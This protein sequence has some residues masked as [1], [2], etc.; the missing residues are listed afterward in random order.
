[1]RTVTYPSSDGCIFLDRDPKHF[2]Y[3]LNYLRTNKLHLPNP[4]TEPGL[5]A[6]V[7]DEFDYFCVAMPS[8]KPEFNNVHQ[9][10]WDKP[11]TSEILGE[12]FPCSVEC[13]KAIGD[14][15][16]WYKTSMT[17]SDSTQWSV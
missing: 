10:I 12:E 4:E 1:M 17:L 9:I 5:Y 11:L 6:A 16:L 3:V 2:S 14:K 7:M 15:L 8:S 13:V